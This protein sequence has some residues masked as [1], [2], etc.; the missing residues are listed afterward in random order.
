MHLKEKEGEQEA[1]EHVITGENGE[2]KEPVHV[3]GQVKQEEQKS[4]PEEERPP[5]EEEKL[6]L[7]VDNDANKE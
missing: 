3:D 2:H 4:P 6:E 5:V 7:V 1:V